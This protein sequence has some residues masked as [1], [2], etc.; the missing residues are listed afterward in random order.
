MSPV[1]LTLWRNE[2]LK[3]LIGDFFI[4]DLQQLMI[5]ANVNHMDFL[6]LFS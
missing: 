2:G 1:S 5:S 4:K 6:K 3:G